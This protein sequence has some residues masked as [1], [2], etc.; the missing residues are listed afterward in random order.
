MFFWTLVTFWEA[1]LI[2]QVSSTLLY[3]FGFTS[4]AGSDSLSRCFSIFAGRVD[5]LLCECEDQHL[6]LQ[7]LLGETGGDSEWQKASSSGSK[8]WYS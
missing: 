8:A 1:I 2:V 7:Q 5:G 6:Q 4:H 3:S